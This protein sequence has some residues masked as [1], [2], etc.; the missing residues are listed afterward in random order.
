MPSTIGKENRH[1]NSAFRVTLLRLGI[2]KLQDEFK[3]LVEELFLYPVFGL[4]LA[5]F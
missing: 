3:E 4:K 5:A 1:H 2:N